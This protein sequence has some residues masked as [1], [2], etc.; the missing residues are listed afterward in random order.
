MKVLLLK[1][2]KDGEAG[3]D[4]Y[5][6]ELGLHGLEATL[7]PVLSFEFVSLPSLFEK[8]SGPESYGGLI[9]TSPRAVEAVKLCLDEQKCKKAWADSLREKWN[10]KSVYVVGK[11]TASLVKA[12]GIT[13]QGE[14]SGNAEKLAEYICLRET[15]GSSPLLFPC[16]ALKREALPKILKEK[17]I[18]LESL[19][20][21]QTA[22][23]PNIQKSL[24][25]Y[26]SQVGIPASIVFFSP[27]GVKFCLEHVQEL[28]GSLI[29]QM[30]FAA[31]GPTTADAMVAE[32]IWVSCTAKNPTPEGLAA[33]LKRVLQQ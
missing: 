7:I 12:I 28:S 17:K 29:D 14:D 3:P 15:S 25:S 11:A 9:F 31:I 13:P 27:S 10:S 4:P 19:T 22:Q 23:H 18:A 6:K 24:T 8:L 30:K 5:V 1:D 16:G 21:Y 2:P 32:G 20:V 26:F 33:E